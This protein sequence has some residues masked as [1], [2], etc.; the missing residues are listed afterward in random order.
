LNSV[1]VF[2]RTSATI[3]QVTELPVGYWTFK[4]KLEL[5]K[6]LDLIKEFK[7]YDNAS[8]GNVV[9]FTLYFTNAATVTDLL[10]VETNGLTKFENKFG[11]ATS[12]GL[13]TS[14]M[15]AF[16]DKGQIT[17][18]ATVFNIVKD[19]YTVRLEFYQKRKDAIIKKLRHDME[20]MENKIRFIKQVVTETIKVHTMKKAELEDYLTENE[21]KEHPENKYD[22]IIKI[23]V[24]N[25]TRDKVQELEE[26]YNNSIQLIK[27][28]E[29]T[30]PEQMW[31]HEL[32]EFSNLHDDQKLKKHLKKKQVI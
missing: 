4:F 30:T 20:L 23:P 15:Y 11:L 24:Y 17:K 29:A 16:N 27:G 6:Q 2:Q 13:N 32:E 19:F 12:K 5:E 25:L 28:L 31:S 10:T 21:Y 26:E 9:K 3:I 18:Y 1:G 22:Y 14:N 7:K 8:A